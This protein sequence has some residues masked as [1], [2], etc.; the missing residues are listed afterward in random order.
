MQFSY[1]WLENWVQTGWTPEELGRRLTMAGLELESLEP[2]APPF[3]GVVVGEVLEVWPHPNADR[4]R[5]ARV[6]LGN[7]PEVQ[8]VCGA[9]NLAVGQRV[10]VA[11]PGATLPAGLTIRAAEVRGVP[12]AGMLCSAQELGLEDRSDGLMILDSSAQLGEDLRAYLQLD[13]VLLTLGLTPNRADCLSIQG[14]ARELAVLSGAAFK[15][16]NIEIPAPQ[17]EH[18]RVIQVDAPAACPRYCGQ[19]IQGI[20]PDARTPDWLR[21]A[22]RRSGLRSIHPVVD[23][24]NYVML[25]LG[26]P[27][28]AFD[29]EK[30]Q[31]SL[32]V[33]MAQAGEQTKLLDGSAVSLDP[34]MLVIADDAGVQAVAGI[35]GGQGSA[36]GADTRSVFIESAYFTP[37]ALAGRARRLGLHTDAS[38]RFE[39]GVD[40]ELPPAAL[41]RAVSLITDICGGRPGSMLRVEAVEYIPVRPEILLRR[42]RLNRV[43]GTEIAD[44]RV[45]AILAGL[46]MALEVAEGG[47]RVRPPSA[48]FDVRIEADLIEEVARVYGYDALPVQMPR[49]VLHVTEAYGRTQRIHDLRRM[50]EA[51]DYNEVITYSFVS[52]EWQA[53]LEPSLAPVQVLNPISQDMSVMRTSLW[54]GLLQTLDYNLKRQQQ[55]V[56]IFEWGRTFVNSAQPV[57]LAGLIMGARFP[58][59]WAHAR[60]S[61]DFYD[62]KA[63][64][65]AVLQACRL[66]GALFKPA[67]H[68]AL[69]PAQTASVHVNGH[70]LGLMGTLHPALARQMDL[71]GAPVLFEFDLDMLL[72]L[73]SD[74]PVYQGWSKFPSLRR[75][76]ALLLPRDV[77]ASDIMAAIL[78]ADPVLIRDVQVF[79]RYEGPGVPAGQQSLA[80]SL[81]LQSNEKTLDDEM[82]N[83]V[84]KR[85]LTAVGRICPVSLR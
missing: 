44:E 20:R 54:P 27:L 75:D 16:L 10:P 34:D 15:P 83:E 32:Q 3:T 35:M 84:I 67:E 58:E 78:A 48:R 22:L 42:E 19:L 25:E 31:G 43:L 37:A 29:L 9:A 77:L 76:L 49:A 8:I 73:G 80:F 79:D 6:A 74:R 57:R 36:V 72:Q 2:A 45:T 11:L 14:L 13:D 71:P 53:R 51:R 60:Q 46:G 23:V 65:E 68:P 41:A 28:H 7:P 61:V 17:E 55:R 33:R 62:L 63:D 70:T 24:L 39:R 56:R 1:Q 81:L 40:P 38:H 5:L 21:E 52:P 66:P 59:T 64:V 12:S 82:V 4:L 47:W 30:L 50:L 18:D 69:N 85:V 26:Q